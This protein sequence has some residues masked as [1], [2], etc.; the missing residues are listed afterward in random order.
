[1]LKQ[2]YL[3]PGVEGVLLMMSAA[4]LML[5]VGVLTLPI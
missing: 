1:M 4:M 3:A 2:L 5:A